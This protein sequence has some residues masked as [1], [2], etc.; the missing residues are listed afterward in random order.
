MEEKTNT[1]NVNNIFIFFSLAFFFALFLIGWY[2]APSQYIWGLYT[3]IDGQFAEWY[4]RALFSWSFP[5]SMSNINPFEGMVSLF[6]PNN[7]W[8]NPGALF[9]S[10]PL[11]R[12]WTYLFSY[13]FY[14]IEVSFSIYLLARALNLSR[15]QAIVTMQAFA[16]FLFPPFTA[17]TH[18]VSFFSGAPFNAHLAALLNLSLVLFIKIGKGSYAFNFLKVILILFLFF[19]AVYSGP[20]TLLTFFPCYGIVALGILIQ[21][22]FN[23]DKKIETFLWK[24]SP[25]ILLLP[26][27]FILDIHTYFSSTSKYVSRALIDYNSVP[28][29]NFFEY[30]K[31]IFQTLKEYKFCAYPQSSVFCIQTNYPVSFFH[32]FAILGGIFACFIRSYR[33]I[34][35]GFI[36][37][38][39]FPEA[40]SILIHSGLFPK[41]S[42]IHPSF[43]LWSAYPFFAIFFTLFFSLSWKMFGIIF[44]ID[45][46]ISRL[47][48]KTAV[49]MGNLILSGTLIVS[50]IPLFG[51]YVIKAIELYKPHPLPSAN[52]TEIISYLENAISLQPNSTFKGYAISYLGA[53]GGGIRP[54]LK[55]E[56]NYLDSSVMYTKSREY[57]KEHY[58]NWHM[59]ADL[60]NYKI[61]TLEEY[62][63]WITIPLFVFIAE[64]LSKPDAQ[65]FISNLNLFSLNYDVLKLL[66]VRFIITDSQ[67]SDS[68]FQQ[69]IKL[70][71]EGAVPLYLYEILNPNLGNY[72]PTETIVLTSAKE[73][74]NLF[75]QKDFNFEKSVV[76]Q[77]L[78]LPKNLSKAKNAKIRFNKDRISVESISNGFSLL[79]LPIQFSHCYKIIQNETHPHT[80]IM[81]ANIVQTALLFKDRLNV[82]LV[83]DYGMVGNASCREEDLNDIQ[84]LGLTDDDYMLSKLNMRH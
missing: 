39:L 35:I 51:F 67:L 2:K 36:I 81:R 56:K 75:K 46:F 76:L 84:L 32:L 43:Y 52:K 20:F 21:S 1:V 3:D 23:S 58:N 60:W 82:D 65:F 45:F 8:L 77:Q 25:L 74:F 66:G 83:F 50:I 13:G 53:E 14:L 17:Y 30:L 26:I 44:R 11:E 71:K 78:N 73:I 28:H 6:F 80:K 22:I 7:I 69:R 42:M 37:I 34:A 16:F 68:T 41:L 79:V 15:I 64:M 38:F 10:L 24:T 27:V 70:Y 31:I 72:S 19:V 57:L 33:W 5:F 12:I 54:H 18:A 29:L 9:L 4:S 49:P 40:V 61:P 63:Q 62:G 48:E 59:L 47:K 55:L